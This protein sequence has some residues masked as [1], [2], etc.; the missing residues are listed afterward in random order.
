MSLLLFDSAGRRSIRAPT[1][2]RRLPILAKTFLPAA[3][4]AASF[5]IVYGGVAARLVRNWAIDEN[6]SHG[7][8]VVPIALYLVWERRGRLA[9]VQP[10]RS[11][12]GLAIVIG[13][14]VLLTAGV[15]GAELF[16]A[17]ISML[18]VIAGTVLFVGG[19]RHLRVLAFPLSFLLL[20][21]PIPAIVFNQIALPLQLLAS[22]LG[23]AGLAVTGVPVLR[24]GNVITLAHAK[25]EVAEACSGIRSL[26]SLLA[27]AIVYG[28]FAD[29][30]A[31]MR[32]LLASIAVPVAIL[33]NGLRVAGT[34]ILAQQFGA[35]A[36][37]GFLHT[38]SGWLMFL[39]AF[40]LLVAL[41][42]LLCLVAPQHAGGPGAA[43]TREQAAEAGPRPV[44]RTSAARILV[45]SACLLSAAGLLRA[46]SRTEHVATRAPL[47]Q[48]PLR[49][50]RWEGRPGAPL[51]PESVAATGANDLLN[52]VYASR[53]FGPVA[54]YIGYYDS[55]REGDT[56][57]SPLNCLPG[58]GWEPVERARVTVPVQE[59][60][61]PGSPV[62]QITVNRLVIEQ[63]GER[64]VVFYWYQSHGRVVASEY[65][66]RLW[67]ALDAIRL[68][69]TDG[70]LVRVLAPMRGNDAAAEAASERAATSF[71]Q[72]LFPLLG[73]H[74]PE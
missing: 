47:A 5:A 14:L 22:R 45:V 53:E 24:E 55:Q 56:I 12:L 4:L 38:F 34:G 21:V 20:M 49:F 39:A 68:N 9:A 18:G 65:W 59:S 37:Q 33:V 15:L 71:V 54:L 6:Y 13:S 44:S 8:L 31:W 41:H 43:A 17:R 1:V 27:L 50:E 40:A 73:R 2:V 72:A 57:H 64:E 23:E 46:A 11:I 42:R 62:R 61:A 48:L 19:W 36:A 66:G 67:L 7:F 74:L 35:S 30:R 28:Y 69:R 26:V 25:L 60:A 52:R 58:A 70:A 10:S 32:V 51:D 3:I 29:P 16:L 63:G